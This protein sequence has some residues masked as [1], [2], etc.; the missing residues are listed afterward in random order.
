MCELSDEIHNLIDRNAN[1]QVLNSA[2][3]RRCFVKTHKH[4]R[5]T[6]FRCY[7]IK[8]VVDKLG[9]RAMLA[10]KEWSVKIVQVF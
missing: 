2:G 8:D 3:P 4:S 9:Q 10:M 5:T 1:F 7:N 6:G